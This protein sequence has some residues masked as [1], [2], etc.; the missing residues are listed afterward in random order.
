[1]AEKKEERYEDSQLY[2]IRHSAAHIMAQAVSE[3]FEPGEAKVAIGPPVEN[4]FYY[5]FDLPRQLTPD[6]FEGIEARM[7]AIIKGRAT[8]V[9]LE[10]GDII[11]VPNSPFTTLKRYFNLII[12]T[13]VTTVAANEGVRA[14]GGEIGV[15]VSVPVGGK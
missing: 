4:G 7:R 1:M 3:L 11:Y 9:Q 15:G 5:D 8:D 13:F 10:P 2:R 6:D 12:N 14:G